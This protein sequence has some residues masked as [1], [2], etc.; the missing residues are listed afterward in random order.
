MAFGHDET[1]YRHAMQL[2]A[3][4]PLE[5]FSLPG[6]DRG[7]QRFHLVVLAPIFAWFRAPAA[8]NLAHLVQVA[9]YASAAVPVWLLARGVGLRQVWALAAGA[10]AVVTPWAVYS[11]GLYTEPLAFGLFAWALWA[12][13]RAAERPSIARTALAIVLLVVLASTRIALITLAPALPLVVLLQTWRYGTTGRLAARLGGLP[14]ALWR[15]DPLLSA[16]A[17]IG[18]AVVVA[19]LVLPG[20]GLRSLIGVYNPPGID[21]RTQLSRIELASS[22]MLVGMAFIPLL[23]GVPWLVRETIRPASGERHALALTL[24]AGIAA[25]LVSTISVLPGDT[26]EIDRY[27]LFVATPLA[28]SACV[29]LAFRSVGRVGVLAGGAVA[30][31]LAL[32]ADWSN[33]ATGEFALFLRPAEAFVDRVIEGRLSTFGP[34]RDA[35]ALVVI[36]VAV[37]A[38][39]VVIAAT[40]RTRFAPQV[41]ALVA[42][43]FVV[44][45]LVQGGYAVRKYTYG[46]GLGGGADIKARAWVDRHVPDDEVVGMYPMARVSGGP[47]YPLWWEVQYFNLSVREAVETSPY[48]VPHS[49][50]IR[51][52]IYRVDQ[53]DGRLISNRP[54]PRYLVASQTFRETGLDWEPVV[55][56]GYISLELLRLRGEAR[57]LWQTGPLGM[58]STIDA[59]AK[60]PI[61]FFRPRGPGPWCASVE[62]FGITPADPAEARRVM[63]YRLVGESRVV[64]RGR[65]RPKQRVLI[66]IPLDFGARSRIDVRLEPRG[67]VARQGGGRASLQMSSIAVARCK[68]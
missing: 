20:K 64:A 50:G 31:W 45:G 4:D 29:A 17:V 46:P 49:L 32:G 12:V 61:A 57:A 55:P 66:E 21:L 7:I 47:S 42:G 63:S 48:A 13:W 60:L 33:R 15:R 10:T 27:Y 30:V 62:A 24:V 39:A 6:Y 1:L 44:N 58:E 53:R 9:A 65:F 23:V 52:V 38:L 43:L 16:I 26:Q 51:S 25:V 56:A 35:D 54:V 3:E 67:S 2:I 18:L 68:G 5:V 41:A 28:L 59:G 8:I 14:R 11:L 19:D 37:A 40:V 36:A 34:L 22:R